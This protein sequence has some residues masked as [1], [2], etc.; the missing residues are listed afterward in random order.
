MDEKVNIIIH[1]DN[2]KAVIGYDTEL[3]EQLIES[4]Q[5]L[6][7]QVNELLK[8]LENNNL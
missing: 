7:K 1:S 4:N 2:N 6:I 5:L 8:R 3:I